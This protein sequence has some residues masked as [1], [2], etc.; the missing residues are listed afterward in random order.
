MKKH[1]VICNFLNILQKKKNLLAK[2]KIREN[3]THSMS[4]NLFIIKTKGI[5]YM[6]VISVR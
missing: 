4:K 2:L 6:K 5:N 1:W 3:E